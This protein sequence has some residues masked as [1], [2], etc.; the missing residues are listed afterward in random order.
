MHQSLRFSCTC[1][2]N[3]SCFPQDFENECIVGGLVVPPAYEPPIASHIFHANVFFDTNGKTV[4]R[5]LDL[6]VFEE[7]AVKVAGTLK[8]SLGKELS[9]AIGLWM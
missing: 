7:E 5:T 2:E 8:G 3:A 6:S 4:Q 1:K 9:N